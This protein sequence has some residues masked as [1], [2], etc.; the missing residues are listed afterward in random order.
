MRSRPWELST[1]FVPD[2]L[3]PRQERERRFIA[4]YMLSAFPAGNWELN[5]PLGDVPLELIAVEGM[6][7]AANLW[8]PQRRRVD[9]VQWSETRYLIIEA[10]IRDPFEGIGRLQTY[11]RESRRTPDLPG[12]A[13]Q[14]LVPRLVVP[15]VIERDRLAAAEAEIELVEFHQPWIDDYMLERQQYFTKEYREVREQKLRTRELFGLE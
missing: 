6:Q 10:K 4:E 8:R 14:E 1:T 12:F 15:F 9:A 7:R 5:V 11:L 13:G 2:A 3:V